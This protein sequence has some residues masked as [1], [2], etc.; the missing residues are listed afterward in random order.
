[1]A[2]IGNWDHYYNLEGD[3]WVRANLVYTPYV[4]PDKKTFCMSFNRD[5]EY[6]KYPEEEVL[7]N[8]EELETRF[9][10]ELEFQRRASKFMPTLRI[11]DADYVHRTIFLEWPGDDFLT[12]RMK[13]PDICPDWQEQWT[14]LIKKMW[15]AK[16]SKFSLHP[17]SW[18]VRNG[19]LVPFNW[20]FSYDTNEKPIAIRSVLRQ[21]SAGRLEK[22]QAVLAEHGLDLD[23][24]YPIPLLQEVAFNSFRA[25]YPQELIDNIIKLHKER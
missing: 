4:S 12:Q 13:N 1:M 7:W 3:E 8:E 17:N 9:Q 24:P 14:E 16:I 25:N 22:M 18:T 15:M 20:F 21:I 23:T 5:P 19:E 11:K 6:H 2:R 10:R